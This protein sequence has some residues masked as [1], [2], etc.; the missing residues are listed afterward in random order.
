MAASVAMLVILA[1]AAAVVAFVDP[2]RPSSSSAMVSAE[3]DAGTSG[4]SALGSAETVI[5]PAADSNASLAVALSQATFPP[6]ASP[7]AVLARDDLGADALASAGLQGALRAPLLLTGSDSLSLPVTA[8]LQ[9]LGVRTV[10]LLGG[11]S[12]ISPIVARRLEELGY[13]V[14]RISGRTRVDTAIAIAQQ[15][16]PDAETVVLVG[17]AGRGST[18]G[19]FVDALAAGGWAAAEG[20]AV[21]FTD[22]AGL[23]AE[24]AS[25]LDG[26]E[27]RRVIVVG[28]PAAVGDAV[29]A[30]VEGRGL[31]VER[32]SGATRY[33]TAARI[34]ER[35][36]A[37]DAD[38][39]LLVA[40]SGEDLWAAG[41]ASASYSS[42][43]DA[44]IVLSDA[45]SMPPET[46]ALLDGL[47]PRVQVVCAPRVV[48]EVCTG[49][50]TRV[51]D[52]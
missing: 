9:R 48:D 32:V 12:A 4:R 19:A 17:S 31:D 42:R 6:G 1:V 28:G 34:A 46:A 10:H 15:Y 51:G 13:R 40:G 41:F 25:Y 52:A 24:S 37:A 44:P 39:V 11:E 43:A 20:Y 45:A 49:A 23:T 27:V 29:L 3:E 5:A 47:P 7:D 14:E 21:L 33:G 30:A 8:E 18:A 36:G 50:R 16:L 38:R 26:S 35:R 22:A 2:S